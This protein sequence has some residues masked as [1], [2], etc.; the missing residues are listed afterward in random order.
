M[1]PRVEGKEGARR[2]KKGRD[3]EKRK[4]EGSGMV[5]IMRGNNRANT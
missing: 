5:F 1:K 4:G 3:R 2:R